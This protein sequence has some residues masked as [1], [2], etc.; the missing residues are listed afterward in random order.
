MEAQET[1]TL[2]G[3]VERPLVAAGS[4]SQRR[5]ALL[6][7]D[8]GTR[9]LLRRPGGHALHDPWFDALVGHRVRL[10]GHLRPGFF[11]VSALEGHAA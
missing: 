9:H 11:L 8:D 5:A 10:R 1:I 3:R 2:E 6:V 4:K 7:L